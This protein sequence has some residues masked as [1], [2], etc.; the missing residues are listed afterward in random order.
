MDYGSYKSMSNGAVYV[1]TVKVSEEKSKC[2]C[3]AQ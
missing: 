2:A 3:L 1:T